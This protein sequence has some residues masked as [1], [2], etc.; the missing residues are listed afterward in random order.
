MDSRIDIF[1]IFGL[2]SGEAHIIRNAGGLVT[3]DVLRS[4]VISQRV[5]GTREVILLHHTNCGVHK[6]N[7]AAMRDAITA[8]TGDYPP[9]AFGAFED[10][11]AAVSEA[12]L[13]VREYAF[14]PSRDRVRG[15]VYDVANG[16]VREIATDTTPV[17]D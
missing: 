11:D 17:P 15:F 13:R 7:E 8:E 16:D 10:L 3:E 12:M 2:V 9:Y 1:A 4:L 14:L 6:L 5:M